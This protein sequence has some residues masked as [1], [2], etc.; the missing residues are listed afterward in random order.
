[1][2]K[3]RGTLFQNGMGPLLCQNG[4]VLRT[5]QP[6][7]ASYQNGVVPWA[8]RNCPVPTECQTGMAPQNCQN[9]MAPVD[10]GSVERPPWWGGGRSRAS[11]DDL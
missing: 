10:Q 7:L 9:G 4:M 6:E 2:T 3:G 5:T 8:N 11:A 1:M